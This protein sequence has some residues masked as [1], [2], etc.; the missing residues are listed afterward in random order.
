MG[1]TTCIW[2]FKIA[3]EDFESRLDDCCSNPCLG[4]LSCDVKQYAHRAPRVW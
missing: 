4:V 2:R 1:N 3:P